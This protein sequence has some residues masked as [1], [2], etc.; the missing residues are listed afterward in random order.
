MALVNANEMPHAA[1]VW[2]A[3]VKFVY[4]KHP[5]MRAAQIRKQELREKWEARVADRA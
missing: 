1:E 5:I 3:G 2:A 4:R